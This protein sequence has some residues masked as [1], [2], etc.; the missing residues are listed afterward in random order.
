MPFA[1]ISFQNDILQSAFTGAWKE[2]NLLTMLDIDY[3]SDK[4][5]L[6]IHLRTES[7]T[8]YLSLRYRRTKDKSFLSRIIDYG[9]IIDSKHMCDFC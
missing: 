4:N 3:C 2:R 6:L 1:K 5:F 8:F 7:I 9:N